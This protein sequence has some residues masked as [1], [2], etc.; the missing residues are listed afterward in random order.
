MS[1]YLVSSMHQGCGAILL[2]SIHPHPLLYQQPEDV[3][4]PPRCCEHAQGHTTGI[5]WTEREI[6]D[7]HVTYEEVCALINEKINV[8]HLI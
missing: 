7:Y 1:C 2:P 4:L 8:C 5:L 3:V 6:G